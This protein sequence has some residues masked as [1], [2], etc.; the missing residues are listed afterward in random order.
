MNN[1]QVPVIYFPKPK[2]GL[3]RKKR[4][5]V[6]PD[7]NV[8]ENDRRQYPLKVSQ[9]RDPFIFRTWRFQFS[10]E[11][12]LDFASL[13]LLSLDLVLMCSLLSTF[14]CQIRSSEDKVKK[15]YYSISGPGADEDPVGLFY[16]DRA[17][18]N[19]FLTQPLDR[20]ER[21]RY[22]VSIFSTLTFCHSLR[23]HTRHPS[24]P[25]WNVFLP[26]S[27]NNNP[28]RVLLGY[29]IKMTYD[30]KNVCRNAF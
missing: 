2:K 18:G 29:A 30:S 11:A 28:N 14:F 19:L 23:G 6:I 5:W 4:D 3:K 21:D 13:S 12:P 7:I 8:S 1:L 25:S 20:E 24:P 9:V 22:M 27:W 15:I 26:Q 16:M 17:S 10:A